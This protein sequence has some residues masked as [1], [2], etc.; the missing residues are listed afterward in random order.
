MKRIKPAYNV[1]L[2]DSDLKAS[3]Q[4]LGDSLMKG[5]NGITQIEI[6]SGNLLTD[7]SLGTAA[8]RVPH[9]LGRKP[10]GY[11]V[12]RRNAASTV[13]DQVESQ[14]EIF[15]NLAASASVQVSLWVF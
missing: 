12:V 9:K 6:L 2:Q 15:L 4:R 11:I 10:L 13:Y 7:I 1:N 14:E 8:T 3:V 5:L